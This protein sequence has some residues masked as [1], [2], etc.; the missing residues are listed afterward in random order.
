MGN[1]QHSNLVWLINEGLGLLF[2]NML[3]VLLILVN[4]IQGEWASEAKFVAVAFSFT[5][6]VLGVYFISS[7]ADHD[8]RIVAFSL[9]ALMFGGLSFFGVFLL[10]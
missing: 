5:A 10:H 7:D 2:A 4:L 3:G 6:V 8:K 1:N 9:S